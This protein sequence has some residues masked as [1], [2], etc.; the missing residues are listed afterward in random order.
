MAAALAAEIG[1]TVCPH[2]VDVVENLPG[3]GELLP[4]D[5]GLWGIVHLA[6]RVRG[7]L[8]P[9]LG[10]ELADVGHLAGCDDVAA[11]NV[12]YVKRNLPGEG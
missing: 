8:P 6:D 7:H 12:S 4:A 2:R 3:K 11:C 5:A 10:L 9:L 1:K